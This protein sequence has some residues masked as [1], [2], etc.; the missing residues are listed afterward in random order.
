MKRGFIVYFDGVEFY[1]G[2]EENLNTFILGICNLEYDQEENE[3]HVYLRRPGLLIG[4]GGRTMKRVEEYLE[5]KI[6][7]HEVNLMK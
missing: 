5:C 4:K 6:V 7:V 3:L 2:E 1:D